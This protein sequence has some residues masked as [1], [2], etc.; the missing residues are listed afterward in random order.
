MVSE[1]LKEAFNSKQK[2]KYVKQGEVDDWLT[3]L[4]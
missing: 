3:S 1:V 4:C 2:P